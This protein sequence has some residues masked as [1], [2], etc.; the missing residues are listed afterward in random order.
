MKKNSITKKSLLA[1]I[2]ALMLIFTACSGG[3]TATPT[4]PET[5]TPSTE[6]AAD[7][8]SDIL[9]IGMTNSPATF[10]L[11]NAADIAGR[12]VQRFMFDSLLTMPTTTTFG[13]ALADSF[14]SED[15]QNYTIKINE[16]AV[17][18]DGTPVTADDVV[19]T[20]NYIANPEVETAR[21][22]N[23]AMLEGTL[24]SGKLEEGLT[25]IPNL[26]AVDDKTVTLKT[27]TPVDPAYIKEFLGF[28]LMMMP[29]HIVE[30]IPIAEYSNSDACNNPTVTSGPYTF[31]QY[32]NGSYV[33]FAANPTYYKGEPELKKVFIKIMNGTNLVTEFQSGGIHMAAG[34]GIGVVPVQDLGILRDDPN[35]EVDANPG[36]NAQFMMINNTTFNQKF[37]QALAYAIDRNLIVDSLLKGE[38]NILSSV[39]AL[40]S[41][42]MN[43][44]LEP[45]QQDVEK[46]KQLLA[47]SGFDTSQEI[48]MIV[49]IGNKVR[50]QSASLIQQDLEAIGLK[51]KQTT[52]D[53]PTVMSTVK[54]HEFDLCLIGFGYTV[55]PDM[56]TYYASTG[57][58]NF[59]M[60]NDAHLDE[61]IEKGTSLTSFDERKAVYDEFQQYMQDNTFILG[62]YSDYQIATKNVI[63][64]GGIT[65]YWSGSLSEIQNW[66]LEGAQ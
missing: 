66:N 46:A 28:E 62:L 17:W 38:G 23:I 56:S 13:P 42:Y 5:T 11:I 25:E 26:I 60:I 52:Y 9:Y 61:L 51:I 57:S 30:P 20:L 41:P 49:P 24:A 48:E 33:E 65:S 58:M 21:G 27:K 14:E 8:A 39:Y 16:D 4:T 7:V 36:F 55:E 45:I 40:A 22:T 19:F 35:I 50:E 2:L 43:E 63:L 37:R 15:D 12:W 29:K 32:Q 31:V 53:F 3:E 47:E 59:G 10:N 18:S 34:G 1:L 44:D 64:N 6:P 54:T